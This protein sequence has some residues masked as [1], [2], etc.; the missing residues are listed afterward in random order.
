MTS[1]YQT[2]IEAIQDECFIHKLE[3][4]H[5]V[6]GNVVRT[7]PNEIHFSDPSTY[8]EIYNM[9]SRWDKDPRLYHNTG[10]VDS[11]FGRLG[12]EAAKERRDVLQRFFSKQAVIKS[13]G[14]ID[15]KACIKA[16]TTMSKL[17]SGLFF[18]KSIGAISSDNFEEPLLQALDGSQRVFLLMKHF[19]VL[20]VILEKCPGWLSRLL[21][22]ATNVLLD[23]QETE[24]QPQLPPHTTTI[25]QHLLSPQS[26]PDGVVPT[27]AQIYEETQTQIFAGTDTTGITLMY[28]TFCLLRSPKSYYKLKQELRTSWPDPSET[29]TFVVLE[30]MPYLNAVIKESLRIASV[31]TGT[32]PRVV[33]PSG[34]KIAGHFIPGGTV[35]GMSSHFVHHNEAAFE[36]ADEFIPERWLQ[37][38]STDLQKFLVPFSRGPRS[39][40]AQSLA[41]AVLRTSFAHVYRKFDLELDKSSP[42][43]LQW[44]DRFVAVYHVPPAR[45]H[46]L[47]VAD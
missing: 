38:G 37:E 26:Y 8:L 1:L 32:L 9:S 27:S 21:A 40:P 45:A 13:Q 2:Y 39:C 5:M 22:P 4:L 18:G 34:A 31:A 23:F 10:E 43:K 16:S 11:S 30:K 17:I 7:G 25:L 15:S 42:E 6:H 28:G 12:Y 35:V 3:Q 36:Q 44:K 24:S 41:W 14:L 33:P 19:P 47:P 29:P 46:F 20:T